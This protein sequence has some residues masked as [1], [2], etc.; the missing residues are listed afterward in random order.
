M[1][2]GTVVRLNKAK[3]DRTILTRANIKHFDL[4]FKDGGVPSLDII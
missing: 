2:I 3:Y 4:H 1:N